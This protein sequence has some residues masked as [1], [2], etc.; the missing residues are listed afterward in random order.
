MNK[1]PSSHAI[2]SSLLTYRGLVFNAVFFVYILIL[3]KPLVQ[4]ITLTL[5]RG[6]PSTW[7]G[8]LL[9]A[10][11]LF[12]TL[13]LLWK[14][15]AFNRKPPLD[16]QWTLALFAIWLAH[17]MIQILMAF[18]AAQAFGVDVSKD[19]NEVF[20]G[21]IVMPIIIKEL[22]WL[23]GVWVMGKDRRLETQQRDY[24][25]ETADLLML[26]FSL[27]AFSV[28]WDF[29]AATTPI[30]IDPGGEWIVEIIASAILY[31]IAYL[32]ARGIYLLDEIKSQPGKPIR[33]WGWFFFA[34]S[35]I[36]ALASITY[37]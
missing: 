2:F 16:D 33:R 4:Q 12:E 19:G 5:K 29:I 22:I 21:L 32:A 31:S 30:K 7:L 28:F 20:T 24:K 25:E 14:L 6:Q 18:T 26:P 11:I 9:T 36:A 13:G 3:Q 23:V 15:P 17:V 27:L 35:G 34:A 37:L 8:L 10:A 1:F